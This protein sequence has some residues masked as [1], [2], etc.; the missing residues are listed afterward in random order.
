[1]NPNY[2]PNTTCSFLK[3]VHSFNIKGAQATYEADYYQA[4][5][6]G[7]V[8]ILNCQFL[9]V[10]VSDHSPATYNIPSMIVGRSVWNLATNLSATA[11]EQLGT[12]KPL[13]ILDKLTNEASPQ[14][15]IHFQTTSL[16]HPQNSVHDR[17]SIY[18][19]RLNFG[20]PTFELD[21]QTCFH[22]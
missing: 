22:R 2:S 3:F 4:N 17:L 15:R 10:F 16:D 21:N 8:S 7:G 20:R 6:H 18:L 11:T 5:F 19:F 14:N 1:M 12:A 13:S 9:F